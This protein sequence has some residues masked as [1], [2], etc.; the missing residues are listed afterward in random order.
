[1]KQPYL[2][3]SYPKS[4]NT[5]LKF[6]L[7]NYFYP[8]IE[9]D[10]STANFY[11][12]ELGIDTI[13]IKKGILNP[14]FYKTHYHHHGS[15]IIFLHRHVGDC[16]ISHWWYN[17]QFHQD[18]RHIYEWIMALDYGLQW[19]EHINFYFPQRIT[20]SYEQMKK[21]IE[22]SMDFILKGIGEKVDY[23]KLKQAIEKSS[24]ENMKKAEE[25]GYGLY[26]SPLIDHTIKFVRKGEINQWV[27]LD[28]IVQAMIIEKN[29]RELRIL[30]YV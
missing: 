12:P 17:R 9:H 26:E 20:V 24:F 2:I 21:D 22:A 11:I 8:E 4:G 10:F 27:E 15:N 29:Y 1:M 25:K 14:K 7:A 6:I 16:L 18:K 23:I 3:A 30:G 13:H 19:R 28:G 5:W